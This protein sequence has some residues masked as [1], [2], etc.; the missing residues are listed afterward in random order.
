MLPRKNLVGIA[1]ME[2]QVFADQPL[3]LVNVSGHAGED[4]C[5]ASRLSM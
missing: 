2:K 1:V 3:F 4:A 5:Y